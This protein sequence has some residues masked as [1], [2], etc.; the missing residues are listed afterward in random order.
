MIKPIAAGTKT[1]EAG[2]FFF[3]TSLL[4][5]EYEIDGKQQ[6]LANAISIYTLSIFSALKTSDISKIK[7][8]KHYGCK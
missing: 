2:I 4:S 1:K 7:F 8:I 6:T 3:T 5:K